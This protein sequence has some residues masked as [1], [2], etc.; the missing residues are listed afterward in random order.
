MRVSGSKWGEEH[1]K[2]CRVLLV[3]PARGNHLAILGPKL[4]TVN[5]ES[6]PDF[7][8]A[9]GLSVAS[10]D[11]S[12]PAVLRR[13]GGPLGAFFVRLRE[14]KTMPDSE[15]DEDEVAA[16]PSIVCIPSLLHTSSI[17]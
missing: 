4:K 11:S 8:N 6:A 9:L 15:D 2:A 17:L 14:L 5:L 12:S 10:S 13:D 3:P 7:E 16:G 1:L